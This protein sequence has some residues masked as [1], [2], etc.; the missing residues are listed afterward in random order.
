MPC[1]TL[2]EDS[3][4]H[5]GLLQVDRKAQRAITFVLAELQAVGSGLIAMIA[6]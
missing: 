5:Q 3:I 4:E 6:T 2:V 1:V